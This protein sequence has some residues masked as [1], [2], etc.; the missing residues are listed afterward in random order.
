[1]GWFLWRTIFTLF[2][3]FSPSYKFK[4]SL[5]IFLRYT[6]LNSYL[7]RNLPEDW[8]KKNIQTRKANKKSHHSLVRFIT[9][10]SFPPFSPP[11]AFL[12]L[13]PVLIVSANFNFK[14]YCYLS[15]RLFDF[16][17][18]LSPLSS[19]IHRQNLQEFPSSDN[20][21]VSFNLCRKKEL[22]KW[23]GGKIVFG[24]FWLFL[25]SFPQRC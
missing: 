23:T 11:W 2:R 4:V 13:H 20:L 6:K 21:L 14:T 3:F 12:P 8:R 25:A 22:L 17:K 5:L 10:A 15:F 9:I 1:M 18:S 7:F 24:F 16:A 19:S